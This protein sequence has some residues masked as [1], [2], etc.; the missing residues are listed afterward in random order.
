MAGGSIN[1]HISTLPGCARGRILLDYGEGFIFRAAHR[2]SIAE[3][4]RYPL[5]IRLLP[6][7]TSS[8]A[9]PSRRLSPAAGDDSDLYP[10]PTPTGKP[11]RQGGA[12]P[13]CASRL[14][15]AAPNLPTRDHLPT[16]DPPSNPR[17]PHQLPCGRG[18]FSGEA[19]GR[20]GNNRSLS[21]AALHASFLSNA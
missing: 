14:A 8:R 7:P 11:R 12:F 1:I 10:A 18:G 16:R 17:P 2:A 21:T 13:P 15:S 9:D 3:F 6:F 19:A 4:S 5:R 20:S